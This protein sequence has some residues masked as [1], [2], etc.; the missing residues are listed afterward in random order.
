MQS[1]LPDSWLPFVRHLA[2]QEETY[3]GVHAHTLMHAHTL[4]PPK[5]G[6]VYRR[7]QSSALCGTKEMSS[8]D[9]TAF[10]SSETQTGRPRQCCPGTQSNRCSC[11]SLSFGDL[12]RALCPSAHPEDAHLIGLWRDPPGRGDSDGPRGGWDKGQ[13][14]LSLWMGIWPRGERRVCDAVFLWDARLAG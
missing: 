10:P 7:S 1:L 9:P 5:H 3:T 2:Q 11:S 6:S 8:R 12:G 13:D 4:S 14:S